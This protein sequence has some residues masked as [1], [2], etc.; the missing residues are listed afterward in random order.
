MYLKHKME[1]IVF[2][3]N[4][5]FVQAGFSGPDLPVGEEEGEG[6]PDD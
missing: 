4:N 1:L 2:E 6:W 3:D 5:A